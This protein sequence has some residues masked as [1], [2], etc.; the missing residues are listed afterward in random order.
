[1]IMTRPTYSRSSVGKFILVLDVETTG[2]TFGSYEETFSKFQA[3][4]FGALIATSETFEEVASL[5]FKVKYDPRYEWSEEAEKIHG[6]TREALEVEGLENEEAAATLAGFILDHFGTGKVMFLG[7]NPWFDIAAMEQ[8]LKPHGVMPDLHHVVLDTSAL[9]W[10]TCSK[11]R[12]NDL[13]EYFLG[14]RA[15][16]HSAL[17]DARM[18]LTVVRTVRQIMNEALNSL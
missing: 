8:L 16:K 4:E 6:I 17:D 3:I 7:H 12:S 11:F 1:M 5:E 15:E 13:F 14:G 2:S 18:T 10:I 9:G